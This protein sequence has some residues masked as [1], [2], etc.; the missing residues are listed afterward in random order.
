MVFEDTIADAERLILLNETLR[1]AHPRR[2]RRELRELLGDAISIP[3]R[4]RDDI[5]RAESED[6]FIVVKPRSRC[7]RQD[8]G[9]S[10]LRPLLRMAVVAIA[11]AVESY[12]AEKAWDL[13]GPA[14]RSSP[15]PKRLCDIPLTLGKLFEIESR[16]ERRAYGHRGVIDDYVRTLASANPDSI[17][18]VFSVVGKDNVLKRVDVHRKV[19]Q[20]SS[21]GQL[22]SLAQRRNLIAHTGD[23]LGGGKAAIETAEVRGHYANAKSIVEAMEEVLK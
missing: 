23:R 15:P 9:E 11:A 18:K 14:L 21:A 4:D 8:F 1:D 2:A 17:G 19:P 7:S 20:G 22:L 16:Y 3:K 13:I 12:V 5:D 10:E 6:L